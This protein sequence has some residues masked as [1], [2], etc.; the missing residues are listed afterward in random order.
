MKMAD[1]RDTTNKTDEPYG[2]KKY[3]FE[4]SAQERLKKEDVRVVYV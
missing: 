1:E 3:S 4:M 2:A